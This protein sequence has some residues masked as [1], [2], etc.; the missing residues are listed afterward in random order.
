MGNILLI[1]EITFSILLPLCLYFWFKQSCLDLK[2]KISSIYFLLKCWWAE[3]CI[4]MKKKEINMC[5]CY[6]YYNYLENSQIKYKDSINSMLFYGTD[7]KENSLFIKFSYRGFK[8]VE[9]SLH[10]TTSNG[11][12]YVLPTYPDTTLIKGLNQEWTAAGLKI[13]LL[14]SQERWRIIYNGMLR[15]L[16]QGEECSDENIEHIRFNFIFIANSVPLKWPDDWSSKLHAEALAFEPWKGPEWI[17]KIKLLEYTGFDQFG[18]MLGQV[19]YSNGLISTLYLRGLHQHR[20][21][22]HESLGFHESITLFGVMP[23]GAIYY[24]S[25][26]STK[27]SFPQIQYG[28]FKCNNEDICNIDNMGLSDFTQEKFTDNVEYKI[29]FTAEG[30]RYNILVK[31]EGNPITLYCG[32]PWNWMNK[33]VTVKLELNGRLGSGLMQLCHPYNGPYQA[34]TSAKL[35]YLKQP[36]TYIQKNDYI[37]H[38]NNKNCQN[39]NVV[40]GKGFSLAMLTSIKD[41]DGFCVTVFALEL[42]LHTHKELQKVIDD[43]QKVSVGKKEADLKK[44][45]DIAVCTIQSTPVVEEVKDAIL[46]AIEDLE[47]EDNDKPHRYA[48][49]SS[50]VGEDSCETSVAGQNSTYLGVQSADD[51]IKSVAMCWASL[52]SYQS[53][54][55]RRQYGM[56]VKTSMGVCVQKMVN[57]DAAGVMFTRHPTTAD[58]SNIVITANHGLGET[59]VSATVEP[60][61]I[62]VHKSWDNKLTVKNTIIGSKKKKMLVN[63]DGLVTIDLHGQENTAICI[64]EKIVLQLA[65]IGVYLETLFGNPRDIEWAVIDEQIYLLQARPITTLYT[66]TEFEIT[67]ELGTGVPSDIDILTFANVGEVFPNPLSPLTISIIINAFNK[68]ICDAYCI[69]DRRFMNVVGMK[70]MLNYYNTF[71]RHPNEKI[72]LLNKVTDIAVSGKV[73][74]TP[75]IHKIARERNLEAGVLHNFIVLYRLIREVMYNTATEIAAKENDRN[76][77]LDTENF[78]TTYSLYNEINQKFPGYLKATMYHMHTSR[79]NV[80]YQIFAM[81]LL[82]SGYEDFVP[83]HFSDIAILLGSCSNIISGE[84]LLMLKRVVNYIKEIEE[85]EEFRQ[86]DPKRAINWLEVNCP[87]AAKEFKNLLKNHGHRCIQELDFLSEPWALRPENLIITL[88][89]MISSSDASNVKKTLNAEETV[90]SLKTPKSAFVK[91]LLKKLVLRSRKA[92][93]RREMTKAIFVNVIHKFRLAYRKLGK[94]MVLEEY[95]PSE[96]LIFF[97]T[98]DEIKQVLNCRHPTLVQK[99]LRRKK[100]FPQLTKLRYAEINVGMPFPIKNEINTMLPDETVKVQGMTVCGGSV[101]NRACVIIDL[102]DAQKIQNGDILITYATDI[103]W[104]PYFVLLSGIVT[105]LG[106]LISHGAVVAREYGLP[107]IISAKEATQMFQTGDTVLLAADIGVL[108]LVK[109]HT[110]EED[111]KTFK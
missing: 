26:C 109:R 40:G 5:T 13:E 58:P 101:L 69:S 45:C 111:L 10:F 102:S 42:Q 59:V 1:I 31:H 104:S 44:Y 86:L 55:Y 6:S 38:F 32:Q 89:S 64:S 3:H 65:A 33:I 97:L 27:H 9:V 80:S 25:V 60:D 105:E 78:N 71:L 57:A 98:H 70:C 103:A 94:L 93:I 99:A 35:Q 37:I 34:K 39:E 85:D 66:W 12:I 79:V 4:N 43:I 76:L 22:K 82:T 106:G 73:V 15:N 100:I 7:Q 74:I 90:A 91:W 30:K 14:K 51:I 11:Q 16:T 21:G 67:H 108:Q 41:A 84:V 8:T 62:I 36:Y 54:E 75:E 96:D 17:D 87:P 83:D 92:V 19:T 28:Q 81:S 18:S 107:C 23:L 47:L 50:A 49:R 68:A 48:I 2:G 20:W 56:F 24:L 77:V 88:Q 29:W 46:K 95:L 52:F 63:S 61:T 53:V 72:T 110:Q